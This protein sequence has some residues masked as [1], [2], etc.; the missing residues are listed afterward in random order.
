MLRHVLNH[1]RRIT[2]G[3]FGAILLCIPLRWLCVDIPNERF[4]FFGIPL[5]VESFLI[6]ALGFLAFCLIILVLSFKRGRVF[7]AWLCPMH[8]YLERVN[9]SR[10]P[11]VQ[12]GR[13]AVL[14][15]AGA[16]LAIEILASFLWPLSQQ[17][18]FIRNP[19]TRLPALAIG[20]TGAG[21]F[22]LLFFH[23][24]EHFSIRACPYGLI[25]GVVQG[26]DTEQMRFSD[27]ENTC[28][29]CG[30][31]D[32]V[33]PMNLDAKNECDSLRCTGCGLCEAACNSVLGPDRGLFRMSHPKDREA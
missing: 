32:N 7:C 11:K 31:C 22:F 14:A 24:K 10:N 19:S 3:L 4:I 13:T 1:P 2:Q 23:F 21:L 15:W 33:C 28:I 29:H 16:L 30:L 12:R 8:W 18:A 20:G 26:P 27:P 6:P 9:S 17:M 5:G 25:Q